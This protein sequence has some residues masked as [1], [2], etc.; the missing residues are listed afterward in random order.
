MCSRKLNVDQR[1]NIDLDVY[2][3]EDFLMIKLITAESLFI[4]AFLNGFLYSLVNGVDLKEIYVPSDVKDISRE[5]MCA[6]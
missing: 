5:D 1:W 6:H 4:S 2:R 3:C